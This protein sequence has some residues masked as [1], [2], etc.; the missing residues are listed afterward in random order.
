M[1]RLVLVSRYVGTRLSARKSMQFIRDMKYFSSTNNDP[2]YLVN[3]D[4]FFSPEDARKIPVPFLKDSIRI[5]MY[6]LHKEEGWDCKRLS[7]NFN[8]SID[9]TNAVIVLMRRRV[10]LMQSKGLILDENDLNAKE[11]KYITVTNKKWVE[12]FERYKSEKSKFVNQ[13]NS[14]D[15]KKVEGIAGQEEKKPL[16]EEDIYQIV[17]EALQGNIFYFIFIYSF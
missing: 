13:N 9:R 1:L 11:G 16:V 12:I 6:R 14:K 15:S 5:E 4:E 2:P 10:E 3:S 8:T 7:E 17:S